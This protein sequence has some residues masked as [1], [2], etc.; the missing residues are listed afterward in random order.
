MRASTGR[1]TLRERARGTSLR[2]SKGAGRES[3]DTRRLNK[4]QASFFE[5]SVAQTGDKR[6]EQVS[7]GRP[8]ALTSPWGVVV[9]GQCIFIVFLC[10]RDTVEAKRREK[11]NTV[12]LI[13]EIERSEIGSFALFR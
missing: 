3:Y 9:R 12:M 6:R 8:T 11:W 1:T 5:A 7:R 10:L 4:E 2:A 13:V